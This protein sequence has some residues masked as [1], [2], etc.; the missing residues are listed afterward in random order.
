[1]AVQG[2]SGIEVEKHPAAETLDKLNVRKWPVWTREKSSFDWFYDEQETCYF[3]EGRV[4]VRT[5][6]GEISIGSGDLVAFP[7]GL[8]CTWIVHEAVRKHYRFS[9]G[10]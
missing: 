5:E 3:L 6:E 7:K 4:T 8:K 10:T 9:S 1:M 2:M